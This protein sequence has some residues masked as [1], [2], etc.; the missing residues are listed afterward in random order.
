MTDARRTRRP[1]WGRARSLALCGVAYAL[2]GLVAV[3]VARAVAP[4]AHVTWLAVIA[5]DVAATLVVFAFSAACDNSS[6][7]DPYW[8]VA[9]LPIAAAWALGGD[10]GAAADALRRGLVLALIAVWGARLT[11]NWL[12]GWPGLTR[13]DWRYERLRGQT[14]WAWWGVSLVGLHLFP[15]LLVLVAL[16]P[17]EA[18]VTSAT[19][20]GPLDA[21]AAMLTAAG[22][23]TQAIADQQ[24]YDFARRPHAPG[25]LL[26]R[27]LWRWSRHPNYLGEILFWT[28]LWSFAMA[29]NTTAWWTL[30]GPLAIVALF[31][32]VSVP[33][34]EARLRASRPDYDA[35]A[36]RTS[37]LLPWWSR[38]A[39]TGP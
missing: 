15:T 22:I 39:A 10:G 2:A 23:A 31:V 29:A 3:V 26:T 14:G 25:A 4:P 13:E 37:R 1:A 21:L 34:M 33:M 17:V 5:A 38:Q 7:Y 30:V 28:G 20:A 32:F 6:V 24:L 35:Y 36:R 9:P 11:W 27:G 18:A 16:V 8:C 19:P 12:R